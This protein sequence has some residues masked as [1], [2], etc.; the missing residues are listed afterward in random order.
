V[1]DEAMTR[2]RKL[3]VPEGK[4]ELLADALVGGLAVKA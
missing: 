1:R 3:G 2:A 4:A